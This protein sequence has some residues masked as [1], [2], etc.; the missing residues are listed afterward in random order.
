MSNEATRVMSNAEM[1]AAEHV[2]EARLT[3]ARTRTSGDDVAA[4]LREYLER[5]YR[6]ELRGTPEDGYLA[7]A[8]ELPGCMT[9][10]ETP[11]EALRLLHDAMAAWLEAAIIAGDPIPEPDENRY[12]GRMLLRMPKSLH[13]QLAAQ[14]KRENVS[15]NQFTMT[16]LARYLGQG[17]TDLLDELHRALGI[18][19]LPPGPEREMRRLLVETT[20]ALL[21]DDQW[22]LATDA[23]GSAPVAALNAYLRLITAMPPESIDDLVQRL[24]KLSAA[25]RSS[26]DQ[27]S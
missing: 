26:S 6:L 17:R 14:A 2:A 19:G 15:I 8:P 24:N 4:R 3:E 23:P 13:S 22:D 5:P 27:P 12:S 20:R 16:L 21:T 10:G 1:T 25:L 7:M 9:A 11:D 18:S